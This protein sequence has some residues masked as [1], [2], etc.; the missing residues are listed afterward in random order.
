MDIELVEET[1]AFAIEGVGRRRDKDACK[2][3]PSAK[4]APAMKSVGRSCDKDIRK[5]SPSAQ[6]GRVRLEVRKIEQHTSGTT[7]AKRVQCEVKPSGYTVNKFASLDKS[8]AATDEQ[9]HEE[10]AVSDTA[11]P[12]R[13]E[14]FI[15]LI[16]VEA[17]TCRRSN[18]LRNSADAVSGRDARDR[19]VLVPDSV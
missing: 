16:D 18:V 9:D 7:S 12:D 19:K 2:A 5:A 1:D 10:A 15:V 17:A 13:V 11:V 6:T 8:A 3:P 14:I 4:N